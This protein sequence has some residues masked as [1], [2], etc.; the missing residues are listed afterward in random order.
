MMSETRLGDVTLAVQYLMDGVM[1]EWKMRIVH[2]EGTQLNRNREAWRV[3]ACLCADVAVLFV[4]N[5]QKL[6]RNIR[7]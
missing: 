1:R 4:G 3:V 5:E 2:G 6:Q 7:S